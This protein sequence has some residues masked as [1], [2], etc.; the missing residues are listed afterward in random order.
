MYPL[1]SSAVRNSSIMSSKCDRTFSGL[2]YSI[3]NR[4]VSSA[5]RCS[6]SH[7]I[8]YAFEVGARPDRRRG[9]VGWPASPASLPQLAVR[10][11][12]FAFWPVTGQKCCLA[13]LN[14]RRGGRDFQS[15]ALS[16]SPPIHLRKPLTC[17]LPPLSLSLFLF[18]SYTRAL[19]LHRSLCTHGP[20][21]LS[22]FVARALS[23][24]PATAQFS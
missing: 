1:S 14:F 24:A 22:L 3:K 11:R 6:R 18:F 16:V 17:S 12:Q 23:K 4:P 19:F 5:T 8:P 15:N 7:A 9:K 20:G 21:L 2:G 13:L 10:E